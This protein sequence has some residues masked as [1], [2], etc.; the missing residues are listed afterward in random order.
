MN[1]IL[2]FMEAG[3]HAIALISTPYS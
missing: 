3:I 2:I 1:H